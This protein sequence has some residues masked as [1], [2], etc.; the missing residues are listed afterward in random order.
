MSPTRSEAVIRSQR[1]SR[2]VR[3]LESS[4]PVSRACCPA[5]AAVRSRWTVEDGQGV[6]GESLAALEVWIDLARIRACI[7]GRT[8]D[9]DDTGLVTAAALD[10][11]PGQLDPGRTWLASHALAYPR[12]SPVGMCPVW[13]SDPWHARELS[14]N[15]ASGAT[16]TPSAPG[17]PALLD[18]V[19]PGLSG[20]DAIR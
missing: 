6:M 13:P 5:S 9:P 10:L 12:S 17:T 14:P 15:S 11:L 16:A 3:S 18:D 1:S 19:A 8:W 2:S 7:A 20:W 4:A